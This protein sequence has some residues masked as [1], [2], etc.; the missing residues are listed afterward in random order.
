L[1]EQINNVNKFNFLGL[2]KQRALALNTHCGN[3]ISFPG[4]SN[5]VGGWQWQLVAASVFTQQV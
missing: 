2:K 4:G 3:I 1:F 5:E